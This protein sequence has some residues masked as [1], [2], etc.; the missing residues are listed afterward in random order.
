MVRSKERVLGSSAFCLYS[1][2]TLFAFAVVMFQLGVPQEVKAQRK[3]SA[4]QVYGVYR[5]RRTGKPYMYQKKIKQDFV[6]DFVAASSPYFYAPPR[7]SKGRVKR[8]LGWRSEKTRTKIQWKSFTMGVKRF[9]WQRAR[10]PELMKFQ[11]RVFDALEN[12]GDSDL[13]DIMRPLRKAESFATKDAALALAELVDR[14]LARLPESEPAWLRFREE[15]LPTGTSASNGPAVAAGT[16]ISSAIEVDT[17]QDDVW[18]ETVGD[19]ET[20]SGEDGDFEP[21]KRPWFA[22]GLRRHLRDDEV[23]QGPFTIWVPVNI[24]DDPDPP[25]P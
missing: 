6:K 11:G 20:D 7:I 10:Y 19:R 1:I 18:E 12:E 17:D 23:P 15:G 21:D 22:R 4:A 8:S 14:C 5:N 9:F 24:N 25:V 2:P 13:E 16:S 3:A